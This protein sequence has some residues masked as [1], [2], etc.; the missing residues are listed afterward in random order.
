MS[1]GGI[2]PTVESL[3]KESVALADLTEGA[4]WLVVCVAGFFIGGAIYDATPLSMPIAVLYGTG[5]LAVAVWTTR[6]QRARGIKR[7][8]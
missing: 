1:R 6:R 4:A 5:V 2:F 3:R 8:F 7:W